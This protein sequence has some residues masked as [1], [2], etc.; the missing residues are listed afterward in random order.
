VGAQ[1]WWL[2]FKVSF[3]GFETE[4]YLLRVVLVREDDELRIEQLLTDAVPRITMQGGTWSPSFPVPAPGVVQ[5]ILE[6]RISELAEGILERNAQYYLERREVLDRYYGTKGDGEVLAELRHRVQEKTDQI[7]ALDDQIESARS[8]TAKVALM[9]QQDALNDELFELQQR[10]QTEQHD[11]FS[12][13]R[14]ALQELEEL[15]ELRH[16]VALVSAAQWR[17]A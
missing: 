12:A 13:R 1:G 16:T 9:R 3:T 6:P 11:S 14:E 15:R 10:L 5:S 2:T 8:M 17:L 4:D 7:A